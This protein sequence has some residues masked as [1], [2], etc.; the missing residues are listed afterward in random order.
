MKAIVD[1]LKD[2]NLGTE[3]DRKLIYI[4]ALLSTEEEKEYIEL[5]HEFRDVLAYHTR[6]CLV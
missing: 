1:K 2:I 6:R 3:E 4:S 5:L